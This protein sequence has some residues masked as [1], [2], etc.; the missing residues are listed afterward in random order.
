MKFEKLEQNIMDMI[1]EEQAKLGYRKEKV[2]LYYPLSSLIHLT[3]ESL[4]ETGMMTLLSD[5]GRE[6]KE[7]LGGVIVT[8]KKD[9]FCFLIPE[10]GVSYVREHT[11]PNEFIKKLVE[12]VG[13]HGCTM[14][15]IR[16]LFE[17]QSEPVIAEPVNNGE[18]DILIRFKE[19]SKDPYYYCF[20]DEGCHIIYHRFLP[21]DYADLAF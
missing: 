1:K 7:H 8:A 12:L 6:T 2:R 13:T 18:F 16:S 4:D 21:E 5:F 14:D 10:A 3:N 20:K 15:Q 11:S 19:G 17:E 9:R